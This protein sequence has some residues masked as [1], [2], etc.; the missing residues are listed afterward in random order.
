MLTLDQIHHRHRRR[1]RPTAQDLCTSFQDSPAR[2]ASQVRMVGLRP[3]GAFQDTRVV[4]SRPRSFQEGQWREL[5]VL[6]R[7]EGQG[8]R[9]T[10]R[11]RGSLGS[12][13]NLGIRG[14]GRARD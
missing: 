2:Q 3:I 5:E 7:T 13:D 6:G 10:V 8:I 9:D 11:N 14:L 12:P 1:H 4:L